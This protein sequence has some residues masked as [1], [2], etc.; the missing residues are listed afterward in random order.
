[1][2]NNP[3]AKK[4]I[5]LDELATELAETIFYRNSTE[6]VKEYIEEILKDREKTKPT[7]YAAAVILLGIKGYE[8]KRNNDFLGYMKYIIMY[9]TLKGLKEVLDNLPEDLKNGERIIDSV[10]NPLA[11]AALIGFIDGLKSIG[12]ERL[13]DFYK[14]VMNE[15]RSLYTRLSYTSLR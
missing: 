15:L 7:W 8:A 4:Y 2:A 3:K 13:N 11:R 1:M 6:I 9:G 10:E 14:Y 12:V 5:N